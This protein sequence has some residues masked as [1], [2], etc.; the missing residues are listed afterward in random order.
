MNH[1]HELS[2]CNTWHV[3]CLLLIRRDIQCGPV[4]VSGLMGFPKSFSRAV[5]FLG[6]VPNSCP[7]PMS[8][9]YCPWLSWFWLSWL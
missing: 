3:Q 5:C 7:E 6:S 2:L 1:A 9:A 4:D 8:L